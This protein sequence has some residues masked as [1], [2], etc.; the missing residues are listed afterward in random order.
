M[1]NNALS[2][3]KNQLFLRQVKRRAA[4]ELATLGPPDSPKS[5]DY[6][7][8]VMERVFVHNSL[9]DSLAGNGAKKVGVYC[10]LAPEELIYAAGAVPLRLCSGS[11]EASGLGEDYVPRDGCPIVKS[12]LG[13]S[14]QNE[15]NIFRQCDVV[16]IPTT[17]DAKRK[18]GEELSRDKEVWMLEV[19]H[20]KSREYGR[21]M[22]L[23]QAYALKKKLEEFTGNGKKRKKI[24]NSRLKKAMWSTAAAQFEARR[25]LL[26]RR[27]E[28]P[29]IWGRHAMLAMNAYAYDDVTAWT[30]A[31]ARLNDELEDRQKRTMTVCPENA[32]R[33]MLAGSP[34]IFPAWKIPSL[35][36]KA[37]GIMV[38]DESCLGDRYL[39]DPVGYSE[40][41]LHDRMIGIASRYLMP[42]VCPSFAPNEDRLTRLGQMVED[43]RVDGV[44]YHVL[45]G[46]INYDFELLRVQNFLKKKNVPLLRVETDYNPEDVEQLRTRLEAFVEML[47]GKRSQGTASAGGMV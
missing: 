15:L 16:I 12:S 31:L 33:I 4:S 24:N 39:Y 9:P 34:V 47:K 30:A 41:T 7:I 28:H 29:V 27:S 26:A 35:L 19:P 13:F 11:Y 21:R 1:S 43:Y 42:C 32:P 22:W 17:C 10:L 40:K 3:K 6:F 46:C 36:E 20:I 38:C 45:K 23:N 44:V 37:G 25:L 14:L 18:L 5:I 2:H 8:H